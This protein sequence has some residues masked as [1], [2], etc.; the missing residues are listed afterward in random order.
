[1]W[2]HLLDRAEAVSLLKELITLGLILPS[3]VSVEKNERGAFSLTM[4]TNGDVA[5]LRAFLADKELMLSEDN[6]RGTCT[7]Y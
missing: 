2:A 6:E 1:M 3:F 5:E 4:K 7:I